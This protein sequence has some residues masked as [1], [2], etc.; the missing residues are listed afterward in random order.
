MCM[1][2][3]AYGY[4]QLHPALAGVISDC[5]PPAMSAKN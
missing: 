5:E 1:C 4:V 2:V 3:S